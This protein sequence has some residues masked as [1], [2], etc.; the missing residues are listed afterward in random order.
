[1][2]PRKDDEVS[3]RDYIEQRL[4]EIERKED[5]RWKAHEDIH[6]MGQRAFDIAQQRTDDKFTDAN[7]FR[8]QVLE[9]R[10]MFLRHDVYEREHKAL[11]MK[12]DAN[13]RWIDNMNGRL[14]AV[15][16]IVLA[17]STGIG[18]LLRFWGK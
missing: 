2:G 1:M 6:E 13:S 5:A 7:R 17:L 3:L 11:E 10:A 16:A 15:G 9:E 18:L 8:E 12:V 14:W 4:R